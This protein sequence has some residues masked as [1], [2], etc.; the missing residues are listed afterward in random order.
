ML[1]L[2][3]SY[4]RNIAEIDKQ[5]FNPNAMREKKSMAD[6][7]FVFSIIMLSI[8]L[9]GC[10]SSGSLTGLGDIRYDET[11]D[12]TYIIDDWYRQE[13]ASMAKLGFWGRILKEGGKVKFQPVDRLIEN[14][15]VD[16]YP[17]RIS[18]N[19]HE[20][21]KSLTVN[22]KDI[23]LSYGNVEKIKSEEFD[24][25]VLMPSVLLH[26]EN[27]LNELFLQENK[28]IS[29]RIKSENFRFVSKVIVLLK[30]ENAELLLSDISGDLTLN[31]KNSVAKIQFRKTPEKME[32]MNLSNGQVIGYQLSKIC[33]K[34]GKIVETV[35]D[36]GLGIDNCTPFDLEHRKIKE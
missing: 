30:H 3:M 32:S 18:I 33:W 14:F 22:V 24:L 34:E 31:Q 1:I 2:N 6:F 20:A 13:G 7:K 10:S 8:L 36:R 26:L 23:T 5:I 19:N 27:R 21:F 29:E 15:D 17:M 35:E 9:S 25:V 16:R 28:Q 12:Q 4:D 11:K